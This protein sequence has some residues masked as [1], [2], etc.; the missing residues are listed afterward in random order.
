M[1]SGHLQRE[2]SSM[3]CR[4]ITAAPEKRV[5][6]YVQTLLLPESLDILAY[7]D[8]CAISVP[9]TAP[10]VTTRIGAPLTFGNGA[11]GR[12]TSLI[13]NSAQC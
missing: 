1:V 7:A 4:L 12:D 2:V 6:V 9:V 11:D 3:G 13:T 10:I 8:R 5:S